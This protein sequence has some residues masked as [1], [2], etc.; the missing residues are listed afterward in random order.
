M[1]LTLECYIL[2]FFTGAFLGWVMEVVC[3]LIQF[4]RFINRGFLIGPYC[5]IYGFGAVLVTAL[6]TP[7]S[8]SPPAVFVLAMAV[9]GTL[10]YL[11]SYAME[12]L[13]HA[14]WWD[15]SHRR[16]NLNGRVCAGTLI[17]FGL[18]GL[19]MVYVARP[20]LFGLYLRL[21]QAW[22]DGLCLGLCALL[23][24]DTVLSWAK[25]AGPRSTARATA[26]KPSPRACARRSSDRACWRAAHF[27]P[28]PTH[29]CITAVCWRISEPGVLSFPAISKPGVR[30]FAMIWTAGKPACARSLKPCATSA[31]MAHNPGSKQW[32]FQA[33]LY[34]AQK[35]IRFSSCNSR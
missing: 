24:G 18:M 26:P 3:K 11:T 12:K 27:A 30:R 25:S 2:L 19:G 14:R 5:P 35:K 22:M 23:L 21:P 31:G 1:R 20:V 34:F 9:C 7:F 29:G 4:G 10:E 8:A 17:P 13:F 32:A 28:S 33:H 6:L 16:F 15:Y